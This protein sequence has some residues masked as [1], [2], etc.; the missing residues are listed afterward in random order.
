MRFLYIVDAIKANSSS[1]SK[2]EIV[3]GL[4]S[5][6]CDAFAITNRKGNRIPFESSNRASELLSSDSIP[7]DLVL[8]YKQPDFSK[9]LQDTADKFL[10]DYPQEIQKEHLFSALC[11]LSDAEPQLFHGTMEERLK[12]ILVDCMDKYFGEKYDAFNKCDKHIA[13]KPVN[14]SIFVTLVK[15]VVEFGCL[16]DA[17][18]RS[19]HPYTIEEKLDMNRIEGPLRERILNSFDAY[20]DRI[21]SALKQLSVLDPNIRTKFRSAVSSYYL[22]FRIKYNLDTAD[23]ITEEA[24]PIL[25]YVTRMILSKIEN[26]KFEKVYQEELHDYAFALVVYVFY[27]CGILIPIGEKK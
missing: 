20:Y 18:K 17:Q 1:I 14:I 25:D 15:G 5:P 22:D 27:E 21:E 13:N 2:P 24:R 11:H 6:L 23:K 3:D 10:N 8:A 7:A 4:L 26:E 16:K 19:L 9:S 12:S